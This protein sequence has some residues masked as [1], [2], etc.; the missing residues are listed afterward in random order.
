MRLGQAPARISRKIS[1]RMGTDLILDELW[2]NRRTLTVPETVGKVASFL[3]YLLFAMA[4]AA[5]LVYYILFQSTTASTEVSLLSMEDIS[6]TIPNASKLEDGQSE[7]HTKWTCKMINPY[8][9]AP[10]S[11]EVTSKV[12]KSQTGGLSKP[13]GTWTG[14]WTPLLE[15]QLP[16]TTFVKGGDS[17]QRGYPATLAPDLVQKY[18]ESMKL[19]D[20]DFMS[21]CDLLKE[22]GHI[23]DK[24]KNLCVEMFTKKFEGPTGLSVESFLG[25]VAT[26]G[27]TGY[28]IETFSDGS[29]GDSMPETV[30]SGVLM[31]PWLD[32]SPILRVTAVVPDLFVNGITLPVVTPGLQFPSTSYSECVELINT[33]V[34]VDNMDIAY[35]KQGS[36]GEDVI[37]RAINLD[38]TIDPC[39]GTDHAYT[40]CYNDT[41]A[42]TT[43][44]PVCRIS[45]LCVPN[46]CQGEG[47]SIQSCASPP[48]FMSAKCSSDLGPCPKS[49]R[50]TLLWS[51]RCV[52]G[53][54]VTGWR[55]EGVPGG[56]F[57]YSQEPGC[58]NDSPEIFT[59]NLHVDMSLPSITFP[60]SPLG[61]PFFFNDISERMQ[62]ATGGEAA[63]IHTDIMFQEGQTKKIFRIIP[64][65][66]EEIV[67]N[68]FRHAGFPLNA[69]E[70]CE[71]YRHRGPYQCSHTHTVT[72]R[73]TVLSAISLSHSLASLLHSVVVFILP[74]FLSLFVK[75]NNEEMLNNEEPALEDNA[76][77]A[78]KL[79]TAMGS[80][81]LE[82]SSP[83]DVVSTE[84][85]NNT[86][87]RA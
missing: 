59:G 40:K 23:S 73:N 69:S 51:E 68:A 4:F 28:D 9:L 13:A 22:K 39:D 44:C 18:K 87:F 17:I 54:N 41:D 36:T 63:Y 82:I 66:N 70:I 16:D 5:S 37:I 77:A 7:T 34:T 55:S 31:A 78:A 11:D 27:V 19:S 56:D 24:E 50:G 61:M 80:D 72:T 32:D 74:L 52:T 49:I 60:G 8:P 1:K 48:C 35:V 58:V 46:I 42:S 86:H 75:T 83:V 62:S 71:F 53:W 47:L 21:Y 76:T 29:D 45:S 67:R 65:F 64:P 3:V 12:T 10:T 14:E 38:G 6:G 15:N 81:H 85:E 57:V 84:S 26:K 25:V 79:G 2:E 30:T 20:A 33:T 43:N